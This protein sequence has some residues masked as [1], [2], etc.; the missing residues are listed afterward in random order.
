MHAMHGSSCMQY[1]GR[2]IYLFNSKK[3]QMLATCISWPASQFGARTHLNFGLT[4][5]QGESDGNGQYLT[6]RSSSNFS[7]TTAAGAQVILISLHL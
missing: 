7:L 4:P 2:L 6:K 5:K 3:I 1:V